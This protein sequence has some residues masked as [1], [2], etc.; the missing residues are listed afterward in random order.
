[1]KTIPTAGPGDLR[2]LR[3]PATPR[4]PAWFSPSPPG[5]G[6]EEAAHFANA[7]AGVVV[8][9]LGTATVVAATSSS[10]TSRERREPGP[11]PRPRR[12]ADRGQGLSRRPGRGG[13]DSR[14][15]RGP[16]PRARP[17]LQALP[18]HQP[19]RDRPRPPLDRGHPPGQRAHGGNARPAAAPSSTATCIA[20]EAPG[21]PS[22]YR[23]PSPRFIHGEDRRARARPGRLLDGGRLAGRRRRGP[24]RRD[25]RRGRAHREG[26][27]PSP[28]R[29]SPQGKV[30]VF[31]DFGAFAATLQ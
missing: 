1:M 17:G 26:R 5:A 18:L 7:A 20:P 24:G 14:G 28:S 15:R 10:S 23:K 8:A 19:V 30:P 13:A 6:L 2:R 25:P 31:A 3:A 27:R 22:A 21:Q 16:A 9:K 11:L 29:R 12:H 4:S